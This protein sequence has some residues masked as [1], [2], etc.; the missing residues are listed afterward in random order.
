M[1]RLRSCVFDYGGG[2]VGGD[3]PRLR[4]DGQVVWRGHVWDVERDGLPVDQPIELLLNT[5]D[6]Y[7]GSFLLTAPAGSHPSL[8]QRLVAVALAERAATALGADRTRTE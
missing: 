3:R 5:G 1:L 4:P 8:A 7:L 2:V 6:R